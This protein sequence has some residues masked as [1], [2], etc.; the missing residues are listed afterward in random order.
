[1]KKEGKSYAFVKTYKNLTEVLIDH[2]LAALGDAYVNFVYSLALSES[3]GIP[4]GVR[5]KGSVLAK[6]VKKVGLRE[7]MP[8]RTS[9]HRLADAA[10]A[11]TVYAWLCHY[12]TLE[13]CVTALQK[14]EDSVESF[15]YLLSIIKE[16]VKF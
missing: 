11:L 9:R 4:F 3:K 14:N 5:V 8:S 1:M 7:Y 13:E 10:E 12:I 16:R 6:A 15:S 2:K